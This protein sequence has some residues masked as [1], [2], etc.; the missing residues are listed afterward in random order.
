MLISKDLNECFSYIKKY[1][2][3]DIY[4]VHEIFHLQLFSKSYFA[5]DMVDCIAEFD[6]KT[7][8]SI[9]NQASMWIEDNMK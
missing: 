8:D 2:N 7:I 1:C 3:F 4:N 6:G 5:N 9:I